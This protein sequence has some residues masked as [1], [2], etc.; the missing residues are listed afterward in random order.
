MRTLTLSGPEEVEEY[1]FD[2]NTL[3]LVFNNNCKS[4]DEIITEL[5]N[6]EYDVAL[7]S[8]DGHHIL[9]FNRIQ[10]LYSDES[11][12]MRFGFKQKV[13]LVFN[14]LHNHFEVNIPF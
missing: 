11:D 3:R 5:R 6:N 1:S 7:D 14:L 9:K 10:K 2:T 8:P 4:Y 13:I 12:T